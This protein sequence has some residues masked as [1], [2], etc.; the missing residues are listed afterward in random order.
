MANGNG[1]MGTIGW[2]EAVIGEAQW[3]NGD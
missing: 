2:K 3:Q 1:N